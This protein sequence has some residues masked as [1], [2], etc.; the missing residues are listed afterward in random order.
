MVKILVITILSLIIFGCEPAPPYDNS[1]DT[2]FG[3]GSTR[4]QVSAIAGLPTT[5]IGGAG[6]EEH[7][8]YGADSQLCNLPF[9]PCKIV[10]YDRK[11]ISWK[12]INP[13]K[14]K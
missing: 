7:W 4:E 13:E 1:I 14:L 8:I 11:V 6:V 3:I 12:D 10:F 9:T 5:I 2:T